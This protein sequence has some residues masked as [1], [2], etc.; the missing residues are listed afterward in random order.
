MIYCLLYYLS[1]ENSGLRSATLTFIIKTIVVVCSYQIKRLPPWRIWHNSAVF[2]YIRYLFNFFNMKIK[3]YHML[4]FCVRKVGMLYIWLFGKQ[5]RTVLL[6]LSLQHFVSPLKIKIL[7]NLFAF[8][9]QSFDSKA[10]NDIF[11]CLT[12]L[13]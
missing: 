1:G 12:S 10:Q 5:F 7:L 8:K 6:L 9:K 2:S 3:I 13:F 11:H 4:V